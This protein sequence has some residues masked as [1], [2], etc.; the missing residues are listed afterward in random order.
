MSGKS[1]SGSGSG[2]G[3]GKLP[4]DSLPLS[5]TGTSIFPRAVTKDSTTNVMKNK[6]AVVKAKLTTAMNEWKKGTKN[7]K[8]RMRLQAKIGPL[9]D[10]LKAQLHRL[11]SDPKTREIALG[12]AGDV[13]NMALTLINP[14]GPQPS[15]FP[16]EQRA[17]AAAARVLEHWQS[18]TPGVSLN[19]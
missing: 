15:V 16:Q 7:E 11:E 6:I 12:F 17:I 8:D 4:S 10:D 5:V 1:G 14:N 9:I 3:R 19:D 2:S 13:D 18:V